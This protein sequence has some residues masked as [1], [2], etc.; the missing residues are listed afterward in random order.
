M[1]DA[2]DKTDYVNASYMIVLAEQSDFPP[3]MNGLLHSQL[4]TPSRCLVDVAS[5]PKS[6]E[7]TFLTEL[8]L[9]RRETLLRWSAKQL[10]ERT[11]EW[12]SYF[13]SIET[14]Q[15]FVGQFYPDIKHLFI[16]GLA[17]HTS[18]VDAFIIDNWYDGGQRQQ[19]VLQALEKRFP[20]N[21]REVPLGFDVLSFDWDSF[22]SWIC[23]G[24][25]QAAFAETLGIKLNDYG[26][27]G[28]FETASKLAS[29]YN[30]YM[31]EESH[32]DWTSFLLTE[33]PKQ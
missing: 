31:G 33:C 11:A 3:R 32:Y 20:P 16:L 5:F 25:E 26:L 27:I 28:S 18:L 15:D 8:E 1:V 19:A 12:P 13:F 17:L 7:D 21:D 9:P 14:A 22:H 2:I 4:V 10:Q 23:V 24:D 6:V 30:D 29:D